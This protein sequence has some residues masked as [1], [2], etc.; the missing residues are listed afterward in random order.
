MRRA[1]MV[2]LSKAAQNALELE[3]SRKLNNITRVRFCG[4]LF[5]VAEM[6]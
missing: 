3:E 4:I 6:S 2:P 1:G 5:S